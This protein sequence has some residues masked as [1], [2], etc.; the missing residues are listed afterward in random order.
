MNHKTGTGIFS[1]KRV[2]RWLLS[3]WLMVL[4]MLLGLIVAVEL[5]LEQQWLYAALLAGAIFIALSFQFREAR[6]W[7]V[8]EPTLETSWA[9]SLDRAVPA[10]GLPGA[11]DRTFWDNGRV[12]LITF[13]DL[14]G[15]YIFVSPGVYD[16]RWPLGIAGSQKPGYVASGYYSFEGPLRI[17]VAQWKVR[18]LPIDRYTESVFG[19]YFGDWEDRGEFLGA[20]G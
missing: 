2:Y 14:E 16:E 1:W 15:R 19:Q 8:V 10:T 20:V 17:Y 5:F 13:G 18:W 6:R 9:T 12:G 4:G 3:Q 7:F 11:S